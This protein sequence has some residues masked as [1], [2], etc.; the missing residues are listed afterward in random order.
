MIEHLDR[1]TTLSRF[2]LVNVSLDLSCFFWAW[3]SKISDFGNWRDTECYQL[4]QVL[5]NSKD[6]LKEL[7]IDMN[8][9]IDD[10]FESDSPERFA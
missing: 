9:E 1:C 4:L 2:K 7:F 10:E 6:S 5:S 8:P 3:K